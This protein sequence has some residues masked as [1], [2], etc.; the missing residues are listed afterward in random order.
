MIIRQLTPGMKYLAQHLDR[1]KPPIWGYPVLE[2]D[3]LH[4][5]FHGRVILYNLVNP[6]HRILYLLWSLYPTTKL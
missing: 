1:D 2:R 6:I 5:F 4:P 3:I